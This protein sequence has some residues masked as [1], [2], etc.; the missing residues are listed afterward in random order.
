MGL[1]HPVNSLGV[2]ITWW[3]ILIGNICLLLN[4]VKN[5]TIMFLNSK[6]PKFELNFSLEI[7]VVEFC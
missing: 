5:T 3:L 4:I 2:T 7:V 1:F 6:D